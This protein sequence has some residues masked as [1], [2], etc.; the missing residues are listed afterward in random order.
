MKCPACSHPLESDTAVIGAGAPRP[1][2]LT[3]CI[4]C[5]AC[6]V[7]D[8]FLNRRLAR[9]QD[10]KDVNREDLLAIGQLQ[11]AIHI[12]RKRQLALRN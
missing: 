5:A 9:L 8:E 2:D 11:A 12:S 7:F 10:L 6:L 1:G 3:V 4:N